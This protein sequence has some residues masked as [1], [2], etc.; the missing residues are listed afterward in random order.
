[1]YSIYIYIYIHIYIYIISQLSKYPDLEFRI[2]HFSSFM[3]WL[4]L[5]VVFSAFLGTII[6]FL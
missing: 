1:M 6:D 2:C 5:P 4:L 3:L